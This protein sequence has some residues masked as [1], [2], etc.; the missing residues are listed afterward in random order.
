MEMKLG[1]AGY[2]RQFLQFHLA[3]QMAAKIVDDPVDSLRIL[4]VGP[5]LFSRLAIVH[6]VQAFVYLFFLEANHRDPPVGG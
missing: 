1:E 4:A 5:W 3:I 2:L 6:V